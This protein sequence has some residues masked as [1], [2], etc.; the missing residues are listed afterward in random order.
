MKPKKT[1][2]TISISVTGDKRLVEIA[3]A[4]IATQLAKAMVV[5]DTGRVRRFNRDEAMCNSCKRNL[6]QP[7]ANSCKYPHKHEQT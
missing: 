3:K 5:S 7:P 4:L 1:T 6:S 2:L